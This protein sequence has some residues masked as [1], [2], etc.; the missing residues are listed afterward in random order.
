MATLN[1]YYNV[2]FNH[3]LKAS[4]VIPKTDTVN[5]DVPGHLIYDFISHSSFLSFYFDSG[6]LDLSFF[7]SFLQLYKDGYHAQWCFNGVVVMPN[8]HLVCGVQISI[9][10]N[11]GSL[12]MSVAFPG[13]LPIET[14]D[15]RWTG[16]IYL[17]SE[18]DLSISEIRIL[19][20]FAKSL[21]YHVQF[22]SKEYQEKR[23]MNQKPMAFISHDSNDK[24]E[25]ARKIA[26]KLTSM[27]CPVWYDEYSLKVGDSLRESIEKGIKECKHCIIILSKN[28]IS[29]S[30]W[31]KTEF[32]SV[33]AR[34]IYEKKNVVLPVWLDVEESDVYEYCPS[35]L[36]ILALNWKV[37]EEEVCRKLFAK[38]IGD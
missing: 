24:D 16:Q 6:N 14:K 7:K 21:G 33:F 13:E 35:L 25:I 37:G 22:R 18:S 20:D 15:L 32:E 29:N 2:D 19:S 30:G 38:I 26:S 3:A 12:N 23:S 10:K 31:T 17:Y 1:E 34:Q 28:F 36:N 4:G 27:G 9:C 5:F 8:S 11:N